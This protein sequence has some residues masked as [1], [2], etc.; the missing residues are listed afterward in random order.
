MKIKLA[1]LESDQSYLNR[2]V[3]AFSTRYDD[4]LQIYSFTNPE[5][6][7][8]VLDSEKIDVLIAN[9]SF[10]IDVTLLPKRCAFAYFVDSK[11]IEIHNDQR[12]I[13]KFQKAEM[14]YK[15]ILSLYSENAGNITGLKM[16]D[17]SCKVIVFTS[18]SGGVGTSTMAASCARYY[19]ATGKRTVYLNLEPFSSPDTFFSADGQFNMSD[20]IFAL[21]SKKAN[22]A[23]KL[24]SCV[25]QDPSGVY[26]FSQTNL[27]LDMLEL[28]SEEKIRLISELK[29]TD[30]YDYIIVDVDF[31][32]SKDYMNIYKQA[33][34]IVWVGDG[35]E[36]SNIK[37]FRAFNALRTMEEGAEVTI[38]NRIALIYNKFSNKT[39]KVLTDLD[40]KDLGGAPR[41]EH[42]TVSQVLEHLSQLKE[43]G[44]ID[45]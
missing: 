40:I 25:K 3:T 24:E 22:L 7:F 27:A 28:N 10:D 21:K 15:Q 32:L 43:F 30:S 12:A 19:A 38:A 34:A 4:K 36:C 45:A 29:F 17:E 9:D 23:M 33:N 1:I 6:A 41:Y 39:S 16:N 26:F 31:A 11:D 14:I 35:S 8:G 42:A 13:C 20:L 44:K 2:I 5:T 18:P 37:I